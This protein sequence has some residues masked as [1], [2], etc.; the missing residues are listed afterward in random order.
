MYTLSLRVRQL[1]GLAWLWSLLSLS[2][3]LVTAQSPISVAGAAYITINEDTLYIQGG[4][5]YT[6]A[7]VNVRNQFYALDLTQPTWDTSNPP[8]KAID[9]AGGTPQGFATA[10][11]SLLVSPDKQTLTFWDTTNLPN[12]LIG[13]INLATKTWAP[14]SNMPMQL[15]QTEGGVIAIAHPT[16]GVV[17]SPRGYADNATLI[18]DFTA[19]TINS[20]PMP[21]SA[22]GGWRFYTFVWS[23]I[24][25]TFLMWGGWSAAAGGASYFYEF[26]PSTNAWRSLTTTGT[27]APLLRSSCMVSAY[28]GNKMVLFGGNPPGGYAVSTIYILDIQ[29]MSWT[30]GESADPAER[31]GRM[32]CAV[33]GDNFIVWGGVQTDAA[34]ARGVNGT[35]LIYNLKTLQWTKQFVRDG[36]TGTPRKDGSGTG[37]SSNIGAIAGGAA[38]GVIVIAAIGVFL[39]RRNRQR[40]HYQ[41]QQQQDSDRSLGNPGADMGL[42]HVNPTADT[43]VGGGY[44]LSSDHLKNEIDPQTDS[45]YTHHQPQ[46]QSQY[47]NGY[48]AEP[49][50]WQHT[51]TSPQTVYTTTA[52]SSPSV[53]PLYYYPP[54]PPPPVAPQPGSH[55]FT[56]T[57]AQVQYQQVQEQLTACKEELVRRNNP[58]FVPSLESPQER[59]GPQGAGEVV[60]S[61][62]SNKG[63]QQQINALQ[64][65]LNRLQAK[66]DS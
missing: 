58:Q 19:K 14:I 53:E 40:Q 36:A 64:S 62:T 22:N 17:Y 2:S 49:S 12:S 5:E 54:P 59:R 44:P 6:S 43:T 18:Y 20:V 47:Q 57:P 1:A 39:F 63:L 60:S 10:G 31:R 35:P 50:Q 25:K 21:A 11:H 9:I 52:T 48:H 27:V 26:N 45:Q 46:A 55:S 4:R 16:T 33:S 23:E 3:L 38:A 66:L 61:D 34:G 8:W 24:R 41:K 15:N 65:E 28:N 13:N 42:T 51:M 56:I 30:Q 32:V 7:G 29:T 37:G